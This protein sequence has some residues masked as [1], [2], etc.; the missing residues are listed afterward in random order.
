MLHHDPD[1]VVLVLYVGDAVPMGQG[2]FLDPLHPYRIVDMAEL[3]DCVGGRDDGMFEDRTVHPRTAHLAPS[4]CTDSAPH[5]P[6][7]SSVSN[8]CSDGRDLH[9]SIACRLIFR[10]AESPSGRGRS[11]LRA[12]A[13]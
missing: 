10:C 11:G 6:N 9:P 3:V 5:C 2:D 1:I 12:A 4:W 8:R 13:G 7:T